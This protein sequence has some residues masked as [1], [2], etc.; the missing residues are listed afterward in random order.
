MAPLGWQEVFGSLLSKHICVCWDSFHCAV[1]CIQ[2]FTRG[3]PGPRSKCAQMLSADCRYTWKVPETKRVNTVIRAAGEPVLGCK[4]RVLI[5]NRLKSHR[6]AKLQNML[7][8]HS[9]CPLSFQVLHATLQS[10]ISL[11]SV[12][13][14]VLLHF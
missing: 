6:G 2:L 13:H 5:A 11:A 3:F 14:S 9:P 12:Q 8:P 4:L 7:L 1:T 10:L